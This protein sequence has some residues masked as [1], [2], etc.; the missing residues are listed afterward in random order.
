MI[1]DQIPIKNPVMLARRVD[2]FRLLGFEGSDKTVSNCLKLNLDAENQYVPLLK[3]ISSGNF[4][5]QFLPP[6]CSSKFQFVFTLA[7]NFQWHFS[8][9]KHRFKFIF[10]F[11]YLMVDQMIS[12]GT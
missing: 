11:V 1:T 3:V 10:N 7:Q 8:K 9:S 5:M 6:T 4:T 2:Y 12:A